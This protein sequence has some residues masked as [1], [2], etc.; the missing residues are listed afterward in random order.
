MEVEWNEL[1]DCVRYT[2]KL[3]QDSMD[4]SKVHRQIAVMTGLRLG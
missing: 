3:S 2:G 4:H 1:T